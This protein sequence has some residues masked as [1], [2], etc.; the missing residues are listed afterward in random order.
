MTSLHIMEC[1][2]TGSNGYFAVSEIYFFESPT[3]CSW[4]WSLCLW[5]KGKPL[6]SSGKPWHLAS[7][8]DLVVLVILIEGKRKLMLIRSQPDH[9]LK[10]YSQR[11]IICATCMKIEI[12]LKLLSLPHIVITWIMVHFS[13]NYRYLWYYNDI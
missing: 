3:C 2:V 11:L 9:T 5:L 4:G 10:H 1:F 7:R 8:P 6:S 13:M 12:S